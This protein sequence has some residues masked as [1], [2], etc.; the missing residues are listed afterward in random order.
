MGFGVVASSTIS[1]HL[2]VN[3][4]KRILALLLFCISVKDI[5]CL[6]KKEHKQETFNPDNVP[7]IPVALISFFSG[8]IAG[9]TGLG[10]G[11]FLIPL[12]I[13]ILHFPLA[14][15]PVY[16]NACMA[17]G[18]FIGILTYMLLPVSEDILWDGFFN[19]FQVGHV[20]WGISLILSFGG[21]LSSRWGVALHRKISAKKTKIFF[22]VLLLCI[23]FKV[24]EE[25]L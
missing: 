8:C 12:F 7:L 24:F 4:L 20:N 25:T 5:V 6:N 9:I 15:V 21:L 3:T 19:N 23:S 16:S 10:G 17:C 18:S 22:I 14:K 13:H 11:I 2:D 1:G